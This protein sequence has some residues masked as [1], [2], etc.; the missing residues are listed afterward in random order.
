M[1]LANYIKLFTPDANGMIDI[2]KYT[3]N[4]VVLWL[5][6]AIPQIV[7]ALLL[8]IF[9]TSYRL[10]IKGQQFFKTVMGKVYM[11]ILLAILPVVIVYIFL[12]KSIIKGVTAGS[13]KG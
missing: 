7:I 10:N 9:F 3:G 5:S 2:I 13:V 11:F 4:T 1:G 12:S 6:G 8:A